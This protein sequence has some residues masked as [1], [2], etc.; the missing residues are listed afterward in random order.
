[1]K[2]EKVGTGFDAPVSWLR[3][4][5][6]VLGVLALL[7]ATVLFGGYGFLGVLVFLILAAVAT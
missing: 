3:V 2:T 4:A 7:P 6:L 1:M 5:L